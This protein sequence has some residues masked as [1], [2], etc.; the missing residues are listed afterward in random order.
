M[1]A[2]R[3]Y[4][5]AIR[6]LAASA[7]GHG[8]LADPDGRALVDNPLCGDRVEMQVKLAD[9]RITALAHKVRGCLLCEASAA[10]I[11]RHAGGAAVAD[12]E[13]A[14]AAVA[15]LLEEEGPV[16]DDWSSLQAFAPVHG[17]RSRYRCVLLPFEALVAALGSARGV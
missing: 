12:V 5:E 3:I 9:G 4:H 11:A 17:H 7:D 8:A 13:R 2:S 15:R 14:R 16:P 6:S 1:T 10:A